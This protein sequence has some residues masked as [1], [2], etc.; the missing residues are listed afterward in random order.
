MK[1]NEIVSHETF[2]I[3][4]GDDSGVNK[5]SI[6]KFIKNIKAYSTQITNAL[7]PS[8]DLAIITG[9]NKITL[10]QSGAE[11]LI[12]LFN[13][14]TKFEREIYH[15]DIIHNENFDPNADRVPYIEY[16]ISC[17]LYARAKG[18]LIPIGKKGFGNANSWDQRLQNQI[19]E[20]TNAST[21]QHNILQKA[22]KRAMVQAVKSV[23]NLAD[24]FNKEITAEDRDLYAIGAPSSVEKRTL[25]TKYYA[26]AGVTK[27]RRE[28][29]K[30]LKDSSI[31]KKRKGEIEKQ[32]ANW[33]NDFYKLIH[34]VNPNLSSGMDDEMTRS[35]YVAIKKLITELKGE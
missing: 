16:E 33:T 3:S 17:Q 5:K 7:E 26:A 22:Q 30:E 2:E 4:Y 24:I 27:E 20:K 35:E 19:N 18:K 28:L 15:N 21:I 25:Y 9:T 8:I 34:K 11:K 31:T 32:M 13:L 6:N 1:N 23:A 14:E 12:Q 10:L 29:N